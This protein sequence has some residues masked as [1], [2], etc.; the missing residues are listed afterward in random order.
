MR[1]YL[2]YNASAP[3]LKEVREYII[4]T[5][6][7]IGNPSSIHHSGREAKKI[8][9][10]SREQI[11]SMVNA[12][13]NNIIFTSGATEANNVIVNSFENI[14]ASKIEHES[15]INN[16]NVTKVE[17]TAE[18]Y[19]D[20]NNL[21]EV[22]KNIKNKNN[23]IIS[24]M[25]AN[26]ETGIIQPVAEITR[27]A[28]KNNI[29]FHTDAVQAVGRVPVNFNEIGCDF[30]TLSSHKIG[31]PKGAGA[32]VAKNKGMLKSFLIGGSQEHN[33]RAG[34]ESLSAIAGFGMAANSIDLNK[35]KNIKK[36]RDFFEKELIN[37]NN[38][39]LLV[40]N[41]S[42]RLPNTFMFCI[43]GISS[44]DILI[45]L[46]IEGFELSAGSACS[47]G[48]IEPSRTLEAMGLSDTILNSSV[49]VSLGPYNN[50]EQAK[51]FSQTVKKIK[52]RF[53]NNK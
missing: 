3:L 34:T 1:C 21:N 38:D 47:S 32:L 2:D 28:K 30:L 6:D 4:A 16:T 19:V 22:T 42:R 52:Q 35:M 9:E 5:L 49:R 27:I 43:P 39:I 33:L 13:K 12:E 53:L 46:D 7:I 50:Y 36:V 8:I 23:S 44:N 14:I 25:L 17:V 41:Q 15:I 20:L 48:K 18:G 10:K 45:A 40:G 26:N 31:G 37:E 24:I 11:S 29:L 51:L